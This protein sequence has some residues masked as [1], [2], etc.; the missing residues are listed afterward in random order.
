MFLKLS[1]NERKVFVASRAV[2]TGWHPQLLEDRLTLS[3]PGLADYAH[4]I[5]TA[6]SSNFF[7]FDPN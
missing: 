2:G 5:T 4:H 6:P 7:K 3:Q 1:S